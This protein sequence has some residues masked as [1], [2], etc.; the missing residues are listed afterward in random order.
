M[1]IFLFWLKCL[2]QNYIVLL[3]ASPSSWSADS[4]VTDWICIQARILQSTIQ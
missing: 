2:L 4:V 3:Q 1:E